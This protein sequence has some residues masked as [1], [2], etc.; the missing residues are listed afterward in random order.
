MNL[1]AIGQHGWIEL[2]NVVFPTFD[3]AGRGSQIL[4]AIG[5]ISPV[6][7]VTMVEHVGDVYAN[8][9][10]VGRDFTKDPG[11]HRT[12]AGHLL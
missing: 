3:F 7:I 9:A 11:L 4:R 10:V 2:P 1:S 6:A 8:G 5:V 12:M